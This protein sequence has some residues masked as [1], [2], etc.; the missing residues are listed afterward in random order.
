MYRLASMISRARIRE[1]TAAATAAHPLTYFEDPE[2][3]VHGCRGLD[4]PDG[5]E[6][7]VGVAEV[8]EHASAAA[9]QHRNE[10]DLDLV[11]QPGVEDLL[12]DARPTHHPD[13]PLSGGGPHLLEL[14]AGPAWPLGTT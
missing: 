5:L 6:L 9:E 8:L 3:Q 12:A 11:D 7:D 13:G 2:A 14:A 1:V 4:H 10:V